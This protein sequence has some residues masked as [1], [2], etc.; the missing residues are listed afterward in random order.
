L[1]SS[2]RGPPLS[3]DTTPASVRECHPRASASPGRGHG[4]GSPEVRNS[5]TAAATSITPAISATQRP[6]LVQ[7]KWTRDS[8]A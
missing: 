8:S 5:T 4:N 7:T 1:T 3:A 2:R 6:Y